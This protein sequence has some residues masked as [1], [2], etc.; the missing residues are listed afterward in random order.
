MHHTYK[1]S[2]I[3]AGRWRGIHFWVSASEALLWMIAWLNQHFWII[4]YIFVNLPKN[5]S[6]YSTR[7]KV[8][9]SG[10]V[11]FPSNT[12][13]LCLCRKLELHFLANRLTR[14]H[15]CYS[16]RIWVLQR[17]SY[18]TFCQELEIF[19]LN[20]NAFYAPVEM[21]SS[22]IAVHFLE[23]TIIKTYMDRLGIFIDLID[24]IM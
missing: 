24:L 18:I 15:S 1:S 10:M 12:F 3:V 13:F 16:F 17:S 14:L 21:L 11:K 9:E 22:R 8:S 7:T 5:L 20:F 23:K 2:F 19:F 6:N 4:F